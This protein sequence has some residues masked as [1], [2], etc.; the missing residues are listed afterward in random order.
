MSTSTAP[1]TSR[2]RAAN[3]AV[4][5]AIIVT[6]QLMIVLDAT[7]MVIAL[8]RIQAGLGF[9][10]AGLSWVQNAYMLAFG[11]LLLLGGRAGDIL[12]RRQVYVTGILLF[13][14][15]SLAGGLAQSPAWLLTARVVQGVGGALAAPGALALI[16]TTFAEGPA[17][18]RAVG[19]YSTV[20]GSGAAIGM[21]L[22][23]LI[24]SVGS[25]RWALF[26][27]VPIGLAIAAAAPLVIRETERRP[28]RFDLA[29]ALTS[30]L[31]MA[32]LVYGF[33]RA[34]DAGWG[35]PGTIA[36]LVLAAG[37]LAGFIATEA[38]VAQPIAP[39]RLFTERSRAAAYLIMT[40]LPAAMFGAFFFLTQ[41]L[42]HQLRFT[43]LQAGLGLLPLPAVM[44]VV[45]RLVPRLLPRYGP[46]PMVITGIGLVLAADLWLSRLGPDSQ[47]LTG[48]L[49]PML[50][51]G[52]GVGT[53]F[54]PTSLTILNGAG[55]AD[56]GAASGAM[57]ALQQTG[58]AVG[59]A[60]LVT[61]AAGGAS[62]GG[63]FVV[64]ALFAAAALFSTFLFPRRTA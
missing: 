37:L 50:L 13:T 12:G 49:V 31:G 30:T 48:L 4:T 27:N 8:P 10:A 40:L 36:A 55:P 11:G 38:R 59:L 58:G 26:I 63:T 3:P 16:N 9:S 35:D 47:Y 41:F 2:I 17:R 29:G 22:G 62:L 42:Q 24:T 18:T 60:V 7:V 45:V 20:S 57:Q 14:A 5:L 23:G 61:V 54:P 6:C 44:I 64:S 34:A 25:W 33:I 39:L 52:V 53:A 28:G 32:S 15:A 21:L 43:P 1:G 51:L 46:K 56:A 19:I